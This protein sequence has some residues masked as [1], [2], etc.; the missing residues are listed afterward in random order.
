MTNLE[1][2]NGEIWPLEE[3]K[4]TTILKVD[5]F[6]VYHHK[7]ENPYI[8]ITIGGFVMIDC[9]GGVLFTDIQL[10]ANYGDTEEVE[11]LRKLLYP[12]SLHWIESACFDFVDRS[13]FFHS[14]IFRPVA[15]N[16]YDAINAFFPIPVAEGRDPGEGEF[17][18]AGTI[19]VEGKGKFMGFKRWEP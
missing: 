11:R 2:A 16:D 15:S 19:F 18:Y 4:I 13:V 14:P 17:Y 6:E 1:K 8:Q 5:H 12:N 7:G 3:I 9:L 10:S